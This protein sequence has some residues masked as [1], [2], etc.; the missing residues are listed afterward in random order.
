M[1]ITIVTV[2]TRG[3]VEPFVALGEGLKNSGHSVKIATHAMFEGVVKQHGLHFSAVSGNVHEVINS[4]EGGKALNKDK[5]TIALALHLRDSAKPLVVNALREIAEACKGADHIICTP[6]TLHISFFVAREFSIPLSIG[7]VNPVGPTRYYHNLI[8]P[9]TPQWW[10]GLARSIYN[11]ASHV[12]V[13]KL[14]WMAQRP[15]LNKAWKEVFSA[16]LPLGEPLTPAF[17]KRPPL[18]LYGYSKFILPKPADWIETQQVTGYWFIKTSHEWQTPQMLEDFINSGKA[19]VYIGFGSMNNAQHKKG[20]LKNLILETIK[21]SGQRAVILNQGLDLNINELPENIFATDPIP[22][23]YLFPKMAAVI[24]HGGAG[25]TAAGL[26]AGA[27]SIITPVI[28][29]QRFWAWRVEQCG[30]GPKP[31]PWSKL[32][33]KN[34]SKTIQIAT[35]DLTIKNKAT[36]MGNRILEE[37]GVLTAVDVFNEFTDK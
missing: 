10:P 27:P 35:S 9:A 32:S 2:G 3:D 29:D 33:V 18:V 28:N 34:L 7:S 36:E 11:V 25:T 31:I 21:Q 26:K 22:F 8:F 24:H 12:I 16:T 17:K 4:E 37:E 5:N 30:V 20:A 6:V 15:L 19:P 14:V 1:K 23:S 13:D